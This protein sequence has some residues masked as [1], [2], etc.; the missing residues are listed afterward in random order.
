MMEDPFNK[1]Y[2][3]IYLIPNY[4]ILMIAVFWQ[5]M[6]VGAPFLFGAGSVILALLLAFFIPDNATLSSNNR[7]PT[8][9]EYVFSSGQL[10]SIN[11]ED[12]TDN[13]PLLLQ[14]TS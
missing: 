12:N 7:S 9:K 13:V 2:S 11:K 4:K 1:V 14:E 5:N 10:E 6:V 8:R 3:N